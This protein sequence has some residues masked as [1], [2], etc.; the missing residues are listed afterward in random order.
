MGAMRRNQTRLSTYEI[1][2]NTVRQVPAGK[3]ASYGQ[4]ASEAGFPRQPRMVGYALHALP[5]RSGVPWHRVINAQGR[6]SFPKGSPHYGKQ[7]RLL[8]KEGV[9]FKGDKVDLSQFGW[10]NDD[11][12][13]L[14]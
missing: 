7:Q 12:D 1:I 6:I 9:V 3:V 14:E 5:A 10:L 2:W 8:R 4:I 13:E 11:E